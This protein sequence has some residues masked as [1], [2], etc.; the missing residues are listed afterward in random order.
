MSNTIIRP[1]DRAEWLEYR[2]YGIG[3]S[4]VASILGLNPWQSPYQL[5]RQKKGLDAPKEETFAMK[6]GHYLEDAVSMFW[7]DATGREVIKSSSGDWI[8][9]NNERPYLR[10]SPDRTFWLSGAR[11]NNQNKGILECKTTQ[12]NVDPDDLPKHWFCQVQYLLGVSEIEQG[13]LAWLC[14]GRTFDYK[15]ITFVPDF[16]GWMIEEVERFWM[17]YIV[18]NL[19]P[20]AVTVADVVTKYARHTDGKITEATREMFDAYNRL[21]DVKMRLDE[22]NTTKEELEAV[23]KV[24][25]GD[26][27]AISFNGVTLATWKASKDTVKF[28]D[29]AF[30]KENPDLAAKY[31]VEKPGSRRF[32]LK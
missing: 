18:G 11:K 25:F 3:S 13:S 32:L 23:L 22:L 29:K 12:M 27:E 31:T 16:Y 2:K 1:K 19:E 14:A 8:I 20:E 26:A 17:D 6:A 5:W 30:C 4:E 7:S 24:G 10:A 28:D 9:V 15:D 21:K